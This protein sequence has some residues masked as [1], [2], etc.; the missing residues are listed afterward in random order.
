MIIWILCVLGL[1]ALQTYLPPVIR[2]AATKELGQS[3][4]AGL[5]PR[6]DL[7]PQPV[8]GQR[9]ERALRNLFES[10]PAFLTLAVLHVALG[11]VAEQAMTGAMVFFFAR[12]AYVPAYILGIFGLRSAL[13]TMSWVG[14][15]MMALPL[16]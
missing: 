13:W 15:I 3:M 5:G 12:V 1:L 14:I 10:L 2:F 16:I 4:L 11:P 9:A 7:P 6:D 8:Q